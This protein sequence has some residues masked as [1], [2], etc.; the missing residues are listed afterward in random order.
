MTYQRSKNIHKVAIRLLISQR[1][2]DIGNHKQMISKRFVE[3][4]YSVLLDN[5]IVTLHP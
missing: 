3:K 2:R 1:C 5:V 4:Y